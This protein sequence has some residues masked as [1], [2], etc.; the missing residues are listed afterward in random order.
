MYAA[1]DAPSFH[2]RN[3]L[4]RK[5]SLPAIRPDSYDSAPNVNV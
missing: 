1:S 4:A 5:V 2:V 3:F